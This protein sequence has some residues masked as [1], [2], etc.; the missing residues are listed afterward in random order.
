M[1][2]ITDYVPHWLS[3]PASTLSTLAAVAGAGLVLH[4]A[5]FGE[6]GSAIWSGISFAVAAVLWYVAD[7]AA[8]NRTA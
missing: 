5:A 3:W 2:L 1:H 4:S 6:V 7:V 8:S